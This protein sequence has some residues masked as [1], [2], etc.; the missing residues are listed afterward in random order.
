MIVIMRK[1]M[2]DKIVLIRHGQS[3]ANVDPK[4]YYG[5]DKH[6]VL[7][8][9]GISQCKILADVIHD[10][11]DKLH[12]HDELKVFASGMVRAQITARTTLHR[13]PHVRIMHD[14]RISECEWGDSK[15]IESDKSVLTRVKS[16]VSEHDKGSLILFTHGEL[17]RIVDPISGPAYNTEYRIYDRRKFED[18]FMDRVILK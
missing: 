4:F 8:Q 5:P 13:Y 1:Q 11:I 16:L 18:I 2:K 17:M 15:Q 9:R 3:V 10:V 7:T 12:T 14:H 6:I